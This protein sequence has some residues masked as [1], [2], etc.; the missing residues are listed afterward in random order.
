MEKEGA[1]SSPGG[2]VGAHGRD[3]GGPGAEK[4]FAQVHAERSYGES[5]PWRAP[6][7]FRVNVIGL[8]VVCRLAYMAG[9]FIFLKNI[10]PLERRPCSNGWGGNGH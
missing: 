4:R 1:A 9:S 8:C 6:H 2:Q 7:S 5:V 10:W 3:V